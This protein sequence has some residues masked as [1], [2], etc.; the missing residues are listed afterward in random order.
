MSVGNFCLIRKQRPKARWK[1]PEVP[2]H[3][4]KWFVKLSLPG[5]PAKWESS[6]L[7]ICPACLAMPA[8]ESPAALRADC[9]CQKPVRRWAAE[10]H[11]TESTLWQEGRIDTLRQLR[12]K[13]DAPTVD[14]FERVY[15]A[16]V[17]VQ[18]KKGAKKNMHC[19]RAI[20]EEASGRSAGAQRVSVL[21]Q[22]LAL[23][24]IRLR[25]AWYREQQK[26]AW[27]ELRRR[28]DAGQLP[29]VDRATALAGNNTIN[30]YINCAQAA[31]GRTA[32][33]YYLPGLALPPMEDFLA[34]GK[35]PAPKGFVPIPAEDYSR[36]HAAHAALHATDLQLWFIVALLRYLGLR[37]IEV[38]AAR[39]GWI[40]REGEAACLVLRNRPEEGFHLK[41]RARAIERR[42]PLAEDLI[43][44]MKDVST[45][46]S[47]IGA[48]HKSDAYDLVYR[49]AS[50]FLR[51]FLAGRRG[52]AHEM[53][54]HLG[55]VI[56]SADGLETAA[57]NL[58]HATTDTTKQAYVAPLMPLP[59]I[60]DK[61]LAPAAGQ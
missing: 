50:K 6:K 56:Y 59:M 42:L 32:R 1:A 51:P 12:A 28:L 49:K 44:T 26:P 52:S 13:K 29:G 16:N 33:T 20:I 24:W 10:W 48:R 2:E 41:A 27:A 53:R 17:P 4:P 35:L 45:E 47:L 58:G 5:Q 55:S 9:R 30:S 3:F 38:A 8:G 43:A 34:V 57:A 11:K 25:Q 40:E 46:T 15:L 36:L 39:P 60:T 19:M 14:E 22:P 37:S 54:K 21:T 18:Q 31:L 7:D 23:T 61:T